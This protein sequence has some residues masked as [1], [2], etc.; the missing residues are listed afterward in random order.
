MNLWLFAESSPKTCVQ[1][2]LSEIDGRKASAYNTADQKMIAEA[3]ELSCGFV[4]LNQVIG[5]RIRNWVAEACSRALASLP[6][7]ERATS[8]LVDRVAATLL[9]LGARHRQAAA[10]HVTIDPF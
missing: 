9:S 3:V 8:V 10:A 5:E 7:D 6:A 4:Y 1:D 2:S